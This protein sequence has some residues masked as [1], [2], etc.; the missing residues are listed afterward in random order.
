VSVIDN[1]VNLELDRDT[2]APHTDEYSIGLD[3]ELDQRLA[4]AIAYVRKDGANFIG[5]TDIGRTVPGR[6]LDIDR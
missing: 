2:H 5:W 1:K 3:R 4:V 6:H